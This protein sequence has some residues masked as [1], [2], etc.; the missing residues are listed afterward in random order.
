MAQIFPILTNV[1][2]ML[3]FLWQGE[4]FRLPDSTLH[5]Q[6]NEG[7]IGLIDIAAKSITLFYSERLAPTQRDGVT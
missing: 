7:G 6:E 3:W 1:V 2:R 4:V 5:K